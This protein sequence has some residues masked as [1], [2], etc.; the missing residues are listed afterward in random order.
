MNRKSM[1]KVFTST[2]PRLVVAVLLLPLLASCVT[3]YYPATEQAEGVYYAADDPGYSG[4]SVDYVAVSYYPWWSVD[5]F[6]LGYGYSSARWSVGIGYGYPTWPRYPSAWYPYGY[7]S[8]WYYNPWPA[9]WWHHPPY[10]WSGWHGYP[11]HHHYWHVH[12][13][14]HRDRH[15]Y[16][17]GG[18]GGRNAAPG[19]YASYDDQHNGPARY[20]Y[21]EPS[22]GEY[23][24]YRS[25][26]DERGRRGG[27]SGPDSTGGHSGRGRNEGGS[28]DGTGATQR[29]VTVSPDSGAT[30]R[31][32]VVASRDG[33][34]WSRSRL[35]P[36]GPRDR[37]SATGSTFPS[38]ATGPARSTPSASVSSRSDAGD[39]TP[40]HKTV[41]STTTPVTEPVGVADRRGRSGWSYSPGLSSHQS[42]ATKS[43]PSRTM[44]ITEPSRAAGPD[45]R[46]S[47]SSAAD[48]RSTSART[49]RSRTL[50]S[51]APVVVGA[52]PAAGGQA[53][54]PA[55]TARSGRPS[56]GMQPA[57]PTARH[58]AGA[59]RSSA[60]PSMSRPAPRAGASRPTARSSGKSQPV[61]RPSKGKSRRDH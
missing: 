31:G 43:R 33:G 37:F 22:D 41:R 2:V 47:A 14:H 21:G 11:G 57:R 40:G 28:W 32:M 55:P 50:P 30:D 35:E 26:D 12:N 53:G 44:P 52:A 42:L 54:R 7:A 18:R 25:G 3:Y 51:T 5:Y 16:H 61:S 17:H 58:S 38:A 56:G 8:W 45:R 59:M 20:A 48:H 9:A 13:R 34:K 27:S 46:G 1:L 24:R 6:Y 19:R 15:N 60:K 29:R 49:P 23:G 10:Y 4:G 36:V 39:R